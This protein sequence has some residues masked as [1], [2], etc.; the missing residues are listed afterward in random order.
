VRNIYKYNV[1][2]KLMLELE[3]RQKKAREM[4]KHPG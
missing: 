1:A 2:Y 3:E 4:V